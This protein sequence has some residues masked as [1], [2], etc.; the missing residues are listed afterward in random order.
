[1]WTRLTPFSVFVG[2]FRSPTAVG[3]M[4]SSTVTTPVSRSTSSTS[5]AITSPRLRPHPSTTRT[6][7]SMSD[8][9]KCSTY[10]TTSEALRTSG[11]YLSVLGGLDPRDGVV[12]DGVVVHGH[13]EHHVERPAGLL[14]DARGPY[15]GERAPHVGGGHLAHWL[16]PEGGRTC[17]SRRLLYV[18]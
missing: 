15:E 8:P 10:A 3:T 2:P 16:R 1:M 4:E 9:L 14:L 12:L 18:S 7:G 6:A 11:R 17:F 13:L 5:R